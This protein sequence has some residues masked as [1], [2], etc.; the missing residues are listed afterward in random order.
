[1]LY[2]V[3]DAR[4]PLAR[5]LAIVEAAAATLPP[6]AFAVQLRDKAADLASLRAAAE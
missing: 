4:A 3:T 2:L 1:M 6:G 5:T